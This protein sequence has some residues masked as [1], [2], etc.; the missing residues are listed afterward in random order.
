MIYRV[1]TKTLDGW[2]DCWTE[3]EGPRRFAS[4]DEAEAAIAD[5]L[6]A[7]HEAGKSADREDFR[8]EGEPENRLFARVVGRLADCRFEPLHDPLHIFGAILLSVPVIPEDTVQDVRDTLTTMLGVHLERLDYR[9]S[10]SQT[11]YTAEDCQKAASAFCQHRQADEIFDSAA[12]PFDEDE[13]MSP[14]CAIVQ[15]IAIDNQCAALDLYHEALGRLEGRE[16][17]EGFIPFSYRA[18]TCVQASNGV[19]YSRMEV[20]EGE[21]PEYVETAQ[22]MLFGD[23]FDKMQAEQAVKGQTLSW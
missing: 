12:Q 14:T 16:T 11:P 4:V 10:E 13:G 2:E 21:A 18:D 7:L 22:T 9:L 1:D 8:I 23:L 6:Q 15:V 20:L 19:L 5:H 17:L 3:N